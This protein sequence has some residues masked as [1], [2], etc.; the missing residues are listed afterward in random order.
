[1]NYYTQVQQFMNSRANASSAT[2][3]STWAPALLEKT[4][5]LPLS[6]INQM[7]AVQKHTRTPPNGV[8]F[9]G[10]PVTPVA[11][12]VDENTIPGWPSQ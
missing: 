11:G 9:T 6:E 12:G 3:F 4:S 10:V 1:M 5:R 2:V 8:E 7:H